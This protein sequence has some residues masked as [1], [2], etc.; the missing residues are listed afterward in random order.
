[1]QPD[2]DIKKVYAQ[3]QDIRRGKGAGLFAAVVVFALSY[4]LLAAGSHGW[5]LAQGLL[6][7]TSLSAAFGW[8]AYCFPWLI[9]VVAFLAEVLV[10]VLG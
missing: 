2:A 1:M 3:A 8:I 10:A 4:A 7:A 5:E 9:D 6:S